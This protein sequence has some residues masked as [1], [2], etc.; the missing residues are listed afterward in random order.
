MAQ[1]T[2]SIEASLCPL[3]FLSDFCDPFS[4]ETQSFCIIVKIFSMK[5]IALIIALAVSSF[6][7]SQLNIIPQ[8]AEIK[9]GTGTYILKQP[10]GF[11][12]Y[13]GD[14][15]GNHGED[16]FKDYL[17]KYYNVTDFREGTEHSYGLPG[18]IFISY[19]ENYSPKD[20]YDLVIDKAKIH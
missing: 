12:F 4:L 1:R 14:V 7:Y 18:E 5:S 3:C 11:I 9:V 15:P 13:N 10:V 2:Q 8:P 20:G 17:K 16:F 19:E 6:I